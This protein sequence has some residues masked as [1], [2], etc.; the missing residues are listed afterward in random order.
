MTQD[1]IPLSKDE[2]KERSDSRVRGASAHPIY[3]GMAF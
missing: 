1:L 2:Y 3:I